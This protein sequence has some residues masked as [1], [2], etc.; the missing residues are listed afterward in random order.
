[1]KQLIHK[2]AAE[3]NLGAVHQYHALAGGSINKVY[4]LSSVKGNFVLK[5]NLNSPNNFFLC[6]KEGLEQLSIYVPTPLII[7]EYS[8][9]SNYLLLQYL[10]KLPSVT[11]KKESD[12]AKHLARLHSTKNKHFG[13]FQN[14]FMGSVPQK[15]EWFN[16][17]K[18]HIWMNRWYPLAKACLKKGLLT[19]LDINK[20]EQISFKCNDIIPK[21]K[22][23]L[24]HGEL[25]NGNV[26][27]T[28]EESYFIDPAVSFGHRE[29]DI[30]MTK[31][32]GGFSDTFYHEYNHQTPLTIGWE[33]RVNFFQIYP[34]L[35]HLLLFGKSYYPDLKRALNAYS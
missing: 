14:N 1:M 25:W 31:M 33:D 18:D 23:C 27:Y 28:K 19:I 30:A 21:E 8:E 34:L 20:L 2:I 24:I 26:L 22:P 3:N 9:C 29:M 35:I 5:V 10:E 15:N 12:L 7:G 6:E 16:D 32:F 13:Y 4:F 11:K 17:L